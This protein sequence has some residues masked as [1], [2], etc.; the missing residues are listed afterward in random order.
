[1]RNAVETGI[2]TPIITHICGIL[3]LTDI[4]V[5]KIKF[6]ELFQHLSTL[7]QLD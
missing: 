6:E 7:M 2:F 4:T 5:V 3:I 1:M